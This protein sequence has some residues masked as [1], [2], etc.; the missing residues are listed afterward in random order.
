[1]AREE[2]LLQNFEY[3]STIFSLSYLTHRYEKL[4]VGDCEMVE[5]CKTDEILR[6]RNNF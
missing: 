5:M 4:N 6:V 2:R 1:M 3:F